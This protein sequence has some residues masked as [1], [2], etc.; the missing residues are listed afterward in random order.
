LI[1]VVIFDAVSLWNA[2]SID[3]LS[4]ICLLL[5]IQSGQTVLS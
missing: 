5:G 3:V 2:A 1:Q 4:F